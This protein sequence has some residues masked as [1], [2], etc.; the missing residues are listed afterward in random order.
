MKKL[1]ILALLSATT[2]MAN[3]QKSNAA[4]GIYTELEGEENIMTLSFN[5]Q[6][7]E[8]IDTDVE[9]NDQI[10]YLKGDIH[11]VKLMLIGDNSNAKGIINKIYKRLGKLGY[12]QMDLDDDNDD[13]KDNSEVWVFSNKKG[14][15]FTEAHFLIKDEDGSGIFMSVYGDFTVTDEKQ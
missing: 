3:A 9:W 7:L 4:D 6:M 10:K 8:S 15:K 11:K 14:N 2:L 13:E 1:F 5:K 12:K